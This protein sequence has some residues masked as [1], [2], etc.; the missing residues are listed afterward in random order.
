MK[1][2]KTEIRPYCP[3]LGVNC[4][5][6][7]CGAFL[8]HSPITQTEE[9]ILNA[10]DIPITDYYKRNWCIRYKKHVCNTFKITTLED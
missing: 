8:S 1:Q 5:K 9:K 3:T 10:A 2:V 4:I 6:E 7:K